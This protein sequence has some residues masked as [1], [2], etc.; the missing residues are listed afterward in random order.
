MRGEAVQ[1]QLVKMLHMQ[2][3]CTHHLALASTTVFS[4][5]TIL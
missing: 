5:I 1:D 4:H 2:K 3:D